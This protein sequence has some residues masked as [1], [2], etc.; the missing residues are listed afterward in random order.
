MPSPSSALQSAILLYLLNKEITSISAFASEI[1]STRPSVS[2][3]L[4][5]LGKRG[6]TVKSDSGWSLTAVGK[7]EAEALRADLPELG[8]RKSVIIGRETARHEKLALAEYPLPP[9]L[10]HFDLETSNLFDWLVS[11]LA[12]W[13]DHDCGYPYPPSLQIALNRV[14]LLL[15][16]ARQPVPASISGLL[17]L[18][19]QPLQTWWPSSRSNL[20][21]EIDPNL[22]LLYQ[23]FLD[24]QVVEYLAEKDIPRNISPEGLQAALDQ[25]LVEQIVKEAR[26]NPKVLQAEYVSA[27]RFL[28]EHPYADFATLQRGTKDIIFLDRG[29]IGKMYEGVDEFGDIARHE[30]R[31]WLCPNCRGIL[32]WIDG[33]PRCAKPSICEKRSSGYAGKQSIAPAKD[34]LRLR[35]SIH[36]R[37]CLPGT[38]EIELFNWLVAKK[39][40]HSELKA[41][42]LWPGVDLYDLRIVFGKTPQV[43]AVDVKDYHS[44][45]GLG[46]RLKGKSPYNYGALRWDQAFFVVPDYRV[47]LYSRYLDTVMEAMAPL[48]TNVQVVSASQFRHRVDKKIRDLAQ[49]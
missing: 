47:E 34:M 26:E 49:S 31:Y 8:K 23:G 45:L 11:G 38:T 21:I 7:E 20:P 27:R 10:V 46:R 17:Q 41:V 40:R 16:S 36:A 13:L 48:P 32:S 25:H 6:L 33:L 5:M 42:D 29:L 2:R 22:P 30:D 1:G 24:E 12:E 15:A 4:N 14:A 3:S 44:P 43:W 37:V 18:F 9:E 35:W 39:A 19:E 28:I